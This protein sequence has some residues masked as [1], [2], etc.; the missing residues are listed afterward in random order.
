MYF[1]RP[2]RERRLAFAALLEFFLL[3]GRFP[4]DKRELPSV[5]LQY[6]AEQLEVDVRALDD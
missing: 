1:A 5:A 4:K 2:S 6:L 3:E